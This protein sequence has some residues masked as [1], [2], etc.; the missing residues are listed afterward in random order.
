M[1]MA[2]RGRGLASKVKTPQS[3]GL[4]PPVPTALAYSRYSIRAHRL[5]G[6]FS[7][8]W[9]YHP[10]DDPERLGEL[11]PTRSSSPV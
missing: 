3:W 7:F 8:C 4:L 6:E 2:F 10:G 5:K 9:K 11:V 1:C